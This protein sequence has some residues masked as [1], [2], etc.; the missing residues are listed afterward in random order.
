MPVFNTANVLFR[1]FVL[2]GPVG[3]LTAS[4]ISVGALV[5]VTLLYT[6]LI[7]I[8]MNPSGPKSA[9]AYGGWWLL[10]TVVAE[11]IFSTLLKG[12]SLSHFFHSFNFQHPLWL[13]VYLSMFLSPLLMYFVRRK[14]IHL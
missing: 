4:Q 14:A 10:F 3:G 7:I 12:W 2:E 1:E 8:K 13:V 9:L 11:L 6:W 5:V